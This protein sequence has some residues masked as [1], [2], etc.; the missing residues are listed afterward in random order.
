[1][2][3]RILAAGIFATSVIVAAQAASAAETIR[4]EPRAFYGATVTTEAGVRVFRPLPAD[5]RMIINPRGS[6][7]L[8]LGI[9][10]ERRLPHSGNSNH[11]YNHGG[12]RT[13]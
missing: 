5:S 1:M 9:E 2:S 11:G 13:Y 4:I 8:H 7:P 6:T 12:H 10:E 3:I